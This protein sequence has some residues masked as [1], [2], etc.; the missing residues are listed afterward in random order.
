MLIRGTR[1]SVAPDLLGPS[2]IVRLASLGSRG[3]TMAE[4]RS[5]AHCRRSEQQWAEALFHVV[6]GGQS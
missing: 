2:S 5:L 6:A 3:V 1:D 4:L